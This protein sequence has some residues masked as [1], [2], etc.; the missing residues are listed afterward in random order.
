MAGGLG[1]RLGAITK[2]KPKPAIKINDRPFIFYTMD[3]LIQNEFKEFIFLLSYKSEIIKELIKNYSK[4]KEIKC[5]FY[6]DNERLGTLNAINNIKEK[7]GEFFFYTNADEISNI[8]IKLMYSDFLESGSYVSSLLKKDVDGN[9]NIDG[10]FIKEK[11]I[12]NS[13]SYIELGCKFI[14]KEIF[15]F[16]NKDYE[17]FE[18][19]LYED[20][21]YKTSI[22]YYITHQ[23]P[24]R[25]DRAID[26]K[27]TKEFFQNNKITTLIR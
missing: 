2:H 7:L 16:L 13:D 8:N 15:A 27:K 26:I 20:L 23:L 18:D 5:S 14:N 12:I 17:K 6:I 21:I 1:S 22:T 11:K 24:L 19:F 25:I 10:K 4:D 3:W 9:L